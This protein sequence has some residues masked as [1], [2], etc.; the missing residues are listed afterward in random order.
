MPPLTSLLHRLA[1]LR[2][3]ATPQFSNLPQQTS[4][5]MASAYA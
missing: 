3:F 5:L 2:D 4:Q 1:A